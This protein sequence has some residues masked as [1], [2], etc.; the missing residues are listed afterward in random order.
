MIHTANVGFGQGVSVTPIQLLSAYCTIA[1]GG[2]KVK[3]H[4]I[5][6]VQTEQGLEEAALPKPEQ[7]LS[8]K[9]I[10]FMKSALQGVVE[11]PHGTGNGA[12]VPGRT[13]A[14]KTGTAQK[15]P[16]HSGKYIGSFVGFSP[17]ADP[18]L[19]VIVIINEPQGAHY[20]GRWPRRPSRRSWKRVWPTCTF[21]WTRI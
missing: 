20:G 3:P 10:A 8:A 16:Y 15:P 4:V 11:E 7:V 2:F 19:A 17:V 6:A 5:K 14:G 18:K 12:R 21:P 13:V 1:N 9:T